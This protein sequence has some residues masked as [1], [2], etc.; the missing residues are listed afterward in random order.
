M[1]ERGLA[2]AQRA[3]RQRLLNSFLRETGR[4]AVSEGEL[5]IPLAAA[6][7]ALVVR[8]CHR[9][10]LGQ[11]S[12]AGDAFRECPGRPRVPLG[13]AEFVATL[14]DEVAAVAGRGDA[15][16]KAELAAQIGNSVAHVAHYLA[17]RAG[18][19]ADPARH[20][21]QNVLLG[22]PFH[23]TPK[24]AEGFGAGDLPRYAPELGATFVPHYFAVAPRLLEQRRVAPGRWVPGPVAAHCPAGFLPLPAHPWQADYLRRRS[25]VA[26]LLTR[27][28]LVDLGPL[29]EPVYPTSS[30]RTVCDPGFPTCWKLP[31]H[32]R[33]TNFVRNNPAEHLRR[34]TD[35]ARVIA[36]LRARW[37]AGF[38]VLL[39]TGYRTLDPDIVGAELAAEFAVLYREHPFTTGTGAPRV[40]AGLL[41]E[42][43]RGEEPELVR[44]VA[45]A[46]DVLAWLRGYLRISLLPLLTVFATDGVSFEAHVQNSLLATEGGWPVRFWVRDLEGVSLGRRHGLAP[47]SPAVYPATEAWFRLRYHAVTNQLGHVLQV[48][49]RYTGTAEERLWAVARQELAGLPY[50]CAAELARAPT[51]PAKANL[52][53]RFADRSERP[54]FVDVPNPLR[55]V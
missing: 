17:E 4:H 8:V 14:L 49:G 20:A 23:P 19:E 52:L 42:G 43:P 47:D 25:E 44:C 9:S 1:T 39:E 5:R 51:L 10:V 30:V 15:R 40:L 41:E 54:L 32:V 2:A 18:R 16:R 36:R 55:E 50:A 11:H 28:E 26:D 37:P 6:P 48:L 27:G 13:H 24:S 34:A 46:G 3:A 35:A 29:G 38:G 33:I 45:E 53:S 21:E 22:H 7:G 12:Y 31:L